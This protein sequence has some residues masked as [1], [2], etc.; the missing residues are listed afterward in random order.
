MKLEYTVYGV[1]AVSFIIL[2]ISMLSPSP[3]E[4]QL[5]IDFRINMI[6]ELFGFLLTI[7]FIY[8]MIGHVG[9]KLKWRRVRKEAEKD[10]RGLLDR[11]F[12]DLS[13]LIKKSGS[14]S[15]ADIDINHS[16]PFRD[17]DIAILKSIHGYKSVYFKDNE[18]ETHMKSVDYPKIFLD[19][20]EQLSALESKYFRFWPT[21]L[22]KELMVIQRNLFSLSWLFKTIEQ[23]HGDKKFAEYRIKDIMDA[24]YRVYTEHKFDFPD[25]VLYDDSDKYDEDE[26]RKSLEW[27]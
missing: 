21:D 4:D 9:D 16:R 11:L 13:K 5:S 20:R 6:A 12:I 1:V 3:N 18:P 14:A 10:L 2:L 15:N 7:V 27:R 17:V 23:G 24:L 25:T 8:Y 26:I 19:A 22:I